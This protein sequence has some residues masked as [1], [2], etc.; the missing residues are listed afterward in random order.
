MR[1]TRL[2]FLFPNLS[3][4]LYFLGKHYLL[5]C[6]PENPSIINKEN[7]IICTIDRD[8]QSP[9]SSQYDPINQRAASVPKI[10]LTLLS[11]KA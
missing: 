3:T 1:N 11:L 5:I 4:V 7:T 8:L 9:I 6:P 10:V 2:V